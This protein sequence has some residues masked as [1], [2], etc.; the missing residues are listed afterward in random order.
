MYR[1]VT[2]QLLDAGVD[3]DDP[4][5][6][7]A[8]VAHMRLEVG[9]D[10]V[11]PTVRVDGVD[12][13]GLIRGPEVTAAV[14]AVSAVPAVRAQMVELQQQVIAAGGPV[15]V[16]GRDIGTTVAPSAP[17]KVFLTA[18]TAARAERRT[19]ELRSSSDEGVSAVTHTR[20]DLLRRD[21]LDSSRAV[22]P[23]TQAPDAVEIDTTAMTVDEVVG[24][25]LRLVESAGQVGRI[26]A[27]GR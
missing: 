24:A 7:A 10:P 8:G 20:A 9:T 22:S 27:A 14:S 18:D 11:R 19:L 16:E 25:I 3:P 21:A 13:S 12:L 6:V 1:A 2:R 26:R 4:E 17:V 23:F 15:V 5:A